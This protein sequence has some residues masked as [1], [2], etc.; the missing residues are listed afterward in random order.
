MR[1]KRLKLSAIILLGLGLTGL[2]AQTLYVKAKSG[3]QTPYTLSD[4][5]K[6]TFS[7]GNLSV[8][9]KAGGTD[10]YALTNLRYLSFN[11]TTEVEE[12]TSTDS[13]FIV[14]PN[15]VNTEL[16]LQFNEMKNQPMSIEILSIDG[17]VVYNEQLQR[18]VTTHKVNI[19]ELPNGLYLC[20]I[21]S[22]TAI[23]TTKFIKQ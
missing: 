4:I 1:H 12:M 11:L 10:A 19:S 15:P 8:N 3:T 20:R 16:N 22:G 18:N 2:Q 14:Y 7:S 13:R 9:K 23:E 6:M 17:R 5:K 21:T